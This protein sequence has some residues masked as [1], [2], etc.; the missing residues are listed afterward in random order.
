MYAKNG[1]TVFKTEVSENKITAVCADDNK[2]YFYVG[3]DQGNL[4]SLNKKGE[5]LKSGSMPGKISGAVLSIG[6]IAS[7]DPSF[8]ASSSK[9]KAY[10][11]DVTT[12][13]RVTKTVT[14]VAN[15]S[16]DGDGTFHTNREGDHGLLCYNPDT[17][18]R[19]IATIGIGQE[20]H[21]FKDYK[22]V[23]S[24]AIA[25]N[26]AYEENMDRGAVE[27][28]LLV[29]NHTSGKEIRK[30][31]FDAPVKQVISCRHHAK[32]EIDDIYILLCQGGLK[33][34]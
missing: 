4:Y 8:L 7:S 16:V 15:Y 29:R 12:E 23:V 28:T 32:E 13:M 17:E 33:K 5:I 31:E 2:D 26:E 20:D 30:L 21:V 19:L 6:C 24:Y 27:K 1:A 9:G 14:D 11:H 25:D 10:F 3:D 22:K 18:A 34:V